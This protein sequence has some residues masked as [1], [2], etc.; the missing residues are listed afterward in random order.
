[1]LGI[2]T[3]KDPSPHPPKTPVMIEGI[4]LMVSHALISKSLNETKFDLFQVNTA[5][6]NERIIE[7]VNSSEL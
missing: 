2:R 7:I 6:I 5:R 3:S 1:M 4:R